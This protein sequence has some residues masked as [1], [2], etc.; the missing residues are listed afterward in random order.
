VSTVRAHRFLPWTRGRTLFG[1]VSM[2]DYGALLECADR[3]R[4]ERASKTRL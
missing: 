2:L 1:L 4:T 3:L